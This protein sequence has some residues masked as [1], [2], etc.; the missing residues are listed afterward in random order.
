[1]KY[2]SFLF[3]LIVSGLLSCS[4]NSS[5]V[6]QG[7]PQDIPADSFLDQTPQ[8]YADRFY[9]VNTDS[10]LPLCDSLTTGYI[11]YAINTGEFNACTGTEYH[12]FTLHGPTG[13]TGASGPTG[14][15]GLPGVGGENG[16]AGDHGAH[17]T[18]HIIPSGIVIQKNG[19]DFDSLLH[20]SVFESGLQGVPGDTGSANRSCTII[21]NHDGTYALTCNNGSTTLIHDGHDGLPG[22]QGDS[23]KSCTI[24]TDSEGSTS[25]NCNDGTSIP[26]QDGHQ[27]AQG[28]SGS[29]GMTC[30]ITTQVS[31]SQI[32]CS[33]GL[34]VPL[35]NGNI[36]VQGAIGAPG[37]D[38]TVT[39]NSVGDS[40]IQTCAGTTVG[41]PKAL[42]N[43]TAY[44]PQTSFCFETSLYTKCNAISYLP[45]EQFCNAG[46]IYDKCSG[47]IFDPSTQ[48]CFNNNIHEPC[49]DSLYNP[50]HELCDTRD[51]AV[52]PFV[53]IGSQTW[54]AKNLNY[55][56]DDGVGNKIDSL[57]FCWG[58]LDH[59]NNT[60]CDSF[61]RFY[62]WTTIMDIDSMYL[63][64]P[65]NGSD[66][67]H[68]GLCPAN[69]HLPA[70]RDF[71]PL[72]DAIGGWEYGYTLKSTHSWWD[73]G[74]G[75]NEHGFNA[76]PTGNRLSD[77]SYGLMGSVSGW[78]SST[79]AY[80]KDAWRNFLYYNKD[81]F[82]ANSL[83][84]TY[85]F[86][87]RCLKDTP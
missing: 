62:Q 80:T 78:W 11:Y 59:S 79:T 38:C 48:S 56:G 77:G 8:N 52:Y 23:G 54:M 65:W 30:T 73:Q 58:S 53:I 42:C 21:N 24:V 37:V 45:N 5:P 16:V 32:E 75:T 85:G 6:S 14:S 50:A 40:I 17:Y 29:N 74:N 15:I 44:N 51:G 86:S 84:R 76:I 36:G 55:S 33:D 87:A 31:H 28:E 35:T 19:I 66:I 2:C 1:M 25:L 39:E 34:I 27:G 3:V 41:W 22:I 47:L 81:T 83:P 63:N 12:L 60:H 46:I 70:R 18:A 26:V 4:N 49:N 57:G 72:R 64:T 82:E 10:E 69:W 20:G 71:W 7:T 9:F 61:G 67:N 68:T 13:D 43:T